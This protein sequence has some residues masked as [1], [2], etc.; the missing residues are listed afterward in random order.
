MVWP[1]LLRRL[2]AAKDGLLFH[3]LQPGGPDGK[4]SWYATKRYTTFRRSVLGNDDRVDF[5][6][7]RRT[8]ATYLE[9]ASTLTTAVN[10]SVTAELMGHTKASLAFSLYSGGLTLD[11]FEGALIDALSLVCWSRRSRR[12]SE[13][14]RGRGHRSQGTG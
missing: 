10:A 2:R 6:S 7:F 13:A 8:F 3:E 5:H 1:I 14:G 12:L 9:R 4:R 11:H